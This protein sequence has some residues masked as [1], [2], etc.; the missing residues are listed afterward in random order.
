MS[1]NVVLQSIQSVLK[2]INTERPTFDNLTV[3]EQLFDWL[4]ALKELT[5][6]FKLSA[7]EMVVVCMFINGDFGIDLIH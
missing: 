5:D 3:N 4:P 6:Q 1:Q 7:M 2:K